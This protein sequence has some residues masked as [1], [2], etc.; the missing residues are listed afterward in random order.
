LTGPARGVRLKEAYGARRGEYEPLLEQK[1]TAYSF[2]SH[3]PRGG[4]LIAR[5]PSRSV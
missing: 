2:P 4:I 1:K 3:T 5:N